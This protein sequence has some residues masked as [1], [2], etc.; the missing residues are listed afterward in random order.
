[1]T[2][3]HVMAELHKMKT[4]MTVGALVLLVA[5][6]A[7]LSCFAPAA[8]S[9]SPAPAGPTAVIASLT[10]TPSTRPTPSATPAHL[11]PTPTDLPAMPTAAAVPRPALDLVAWHKAHGGRWAEE[12]LDAIPMAVLVPEATFV[13]QPIPVAN[14]RGGAI[15]S[16][17]CAGYVFLQFGNVTPA[18]FARH[19]DTVGALFIRSALMSFV[20]YGAN[21]VLGWDRVSTEIPMD[22]RGMIGEANRRDIPVFLQLNYSDYVPGPVRTGVEALQK[23]DNVGRTVS[24]LQALEADGLHVTGVTFG[25]EIGDESGYGAAKPTL[26]NDDLVARYLAYTRALKDAFPALQILAFD[27]YIAATRDQVGSYIPLL[28]AVRAAEV[29]DGRALLDGF[30]FRE[31]YVYMN[32]RGQVRST[33]EILDDTESLYRSVPAY[34]YDVMG[35]VS[36]PWPDRD[37]LHL[38]LTETQRI[39]QRDLVIG[40]TEYLPAGPVQIS[41]SDTSPYEDQVFLLHYADLA[42]I[43]AELGLDVL[44]TWMFANDAQQAKCYIDNQERAGSNYAVHAQLARHLRGVM[45]TVT[46]PLPYEQLRVKVYAARDGDTTFVMLLNKDAEREHA[47]RV[48]LPS[49]LDLSLRLPPRSYTGILSEPAGVIVTGIAP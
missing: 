16:T 14:R 29:A 43:Y 46:R 12:P 34:R 15:A 30:V 37:Y 49:K 1:M 47:V 40:L 23:A 20:D 18:M 35:Q 33:Q 25:D 10:P 2:T 21:R 3:I 26:G 41:E 44:S 22:V 17:L 8:P 48:M 5:A 42:G 28:E 38:L 7:L 13:V 31:S 11:G 32:D 27:S 24:F 9:P 39:F 36:S 19:A 45:L 4:H 6:S